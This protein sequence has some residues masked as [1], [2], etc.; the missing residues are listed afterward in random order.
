[1]RKDSATPFH[2]MVG[3]FLDMMRAERNASLNTCAAYARDLENAALFLARRRTDLADARED[4]LRAYL[5]SQRSFAPRTQARRLSSLKQF[6]RFLCSEKYRAEDP[7]RALDAPK[8]GRALPKYLSEKDVRALLKA[9][10]SH[11]GDEGVR[12]R[13]MVELVYASGLRVSELMGLP[14]SGVLFDR[15]VV[16]VRGKG[17]KERMVPLGEP[18]IEALKAWLPVRKGW[19]GERASPYLFPSFSSR[20]A[21]PMTRQ[22]FFQILKAL[23]CTAGLDPRRLSPHVIRHAFATHLIEHGA[24]LRSVQSMLGHADIATT[25]IYTHL[26]NDKL[27][28]TLAEHH[29]LA[30]ARLGKGGGS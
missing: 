25:Q 19:L 6:Y 28:R 3:A 10:A 16:L 22:R 26:A 30:Q 4:D 9:A 27:A 5:Q 7:T 2:G 23:A 15:C 29:P 20:R 21:A 8:M 14:V 13:A 18:A 1:M 17:D 12:L 11:P 24:D